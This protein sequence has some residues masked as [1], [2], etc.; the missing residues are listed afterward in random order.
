MEKQSPLG[1][2]GIAQQISQLSSPLSGHSQAT[3]FFVLH[4]TVGALGIRSFEINN[5]SS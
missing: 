4:A 3:V 2:E 5:Y 1:S